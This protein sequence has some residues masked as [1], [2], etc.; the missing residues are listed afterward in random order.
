MH[1]EHFFN[2]YLDMA[3]SRLFVITYFNRCLKSDKKIVKFMYTVCLIVCVK[4]LYTLTASLQMSS[5]V[6]LFHR[7]ALS[8]HLLAIK[9]TH[10]FPNNGLIRKS[11]KPTLPVHTTLT[12]L[13]YSAM[14]LMF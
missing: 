5:H 13:H 2:I 10:C 9:P 8:M 4:I 3:L 14:G 11:N 6:R 7:N 12:I 1:A